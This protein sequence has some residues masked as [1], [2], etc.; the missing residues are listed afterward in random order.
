MLVHRKPRKY[1]LLVDRLNTLLGALGLSTILKSPTDLTP[2]L[3]IAIL[4]AFLC[5]HFPIDFSAS[6]EGAALQQT[7]I[8]LG[9]LE[10]E[11]LEMDVGLSNMDPRK[12]A[13]G[14]Q[15]E[16][17]VIGELLC[18]V[19]CR[20]G[21]VADD[22]STMQSSLPTHTQPPVDSSAT[23]TP[24]KH[25]HTPTSYSSH[26]NTESIT[27][28]DSLETIAPGRKPI[29]TSPLSLRPR[30]IHDIL[31]P[32]LILSPDL[33]SPFAGPSSYYLNYSSET[34]EQNVRYTGYISAV[35]QD[36]EL[37]TFESNRSLSSRAGSEE[38]EVRYFS[39]RRVPET[40][41][42]DHQIP[43]YKLPPLF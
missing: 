23:S 6:R 20:H 39:S 29:L 1:P 15:E 5:M 31:S 41:L 19:G 11:V 37:L 35:D 32:S 26:R 18:W 9:V 4:E 12:L 2:P 8:F 7:K 17:L 33:D 38:D 21:I 16:V 40:H 24:T 42:V 22:H 36:L 27:S 13:S 10:T 28:L 25:T 43:S 30:C 34:S 14:E 3:L